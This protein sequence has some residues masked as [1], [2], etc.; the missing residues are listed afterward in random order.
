MSAQKLPSAI[1]QTFTYGYESNLA[2]ADASGRAHLN[3]ATSIREARYPY[4]FEGQIFEARAVARML[5]TLSQ[6]VGSRFYFP[7]NMLKRIIAERDP[8]ITSG[9][10]AL[11][12]EGFSACASTYARVDILPE[13]YDGEIVEKGTTNVDFNPALKASLASTLSTDKLALS[14][15]KEEFAFTRE[16]APIIEKKVKLPLRWLKG[17]VEVQAYQARMEKKLEVGKTE[18]LNF[19]RGLP[20]N[21]QTQSLF[22]VVP[23]GRNLRLSQASSQRGGDQLVQVGGLKRL[24]LLR[25]LIP[26]V[27]TTA[28]PALTIYSEPDGQASEWTIHFGKG[29]SF[30]LTI[31]SQPFRGF[32]GEGQV[33][34]QLTELDED[35]LAGIRAALKWQQDL[36]LNEL[37]QI[38]GST[39]EQVRILL[40]A[41][42]SRGLVGFDLASGSYF[43]RELPFDLSLVDGMHPR[44]IAAQKLVTQNKVKQ[45]ADA[46]NQL[47]FEVQGSDTMH[48]ITVHL[49]SGSFHCTCQW[50]ST[51]QGKRGLCKHI[52]AA[53]LK[54][55]ENDDLKE[56]DDN[57]S[58]PEKERGS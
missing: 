15:G 14:V 19:L 44:L 9:S 23:A 8:V 40:A 25:E 57:L 12:F 7:P 4:F 13:A 33:L 29:L 5:L 11:R 28:Q 48:I 22:Y 42:G 27:S 10:G 6:V 53:K 2:A 17:F 35:K 56:S 52:L 37:A 43:H 34:S 58:V 54:L 36:Q 16:N 51:Y 30:S 50:F 47:N 41:L 1:N 3:L 21:A 45:L 18:A 38:T 26:L 31:T 24:Q 20:T 46:P 39:V 32:S 49:G 55:A